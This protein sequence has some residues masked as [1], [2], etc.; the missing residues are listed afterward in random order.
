M[1]HIV[2]ISLDKEHLET[3]CKIG[4]GTD[5]CKFLAGGPEGLLCGKSIP[6]LKAALD[7]KEGMSA[8]SDNCGGR[9]GHLNFSIL[10]ELRH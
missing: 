5:C 4:R 1:K 10:N 8:Q 3:V 6:Q 7:I 2:S 9:S